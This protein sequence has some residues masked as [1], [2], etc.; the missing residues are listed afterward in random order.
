MLK[1]VLF[2]MDGVIIDSEP[3]HAKAAVLALQ[4][5]NIS[6]PLEY[7]NGFVGCTTYSMCQRI[8]ADY[9]LSLP[10]EELLRSINDSKNNLVQTEGYVVI[11]YVI[12]LIKDL[13]SHG[14]KLMIASS[15]YPEAIEEVM[16]T[17]ELTEYFE[18]Y[19]A[20]SMVTHPKPAPDIFLLAADR[21]KVRPDECIII[22]DSHHGVSAAAA[23]GITSIG[24]VN[25]NSGEQDLRKAAILVEGFDE[26]DYSF[27][28]RIYQTAHKE[29]VTV[30]STE[31]FILRELTAEDMD[32]LFE[33]YRQPEIRAYLEDFSDDLSTERKKLQAY[34]DHIYGYY[35]YGL[36]GV[37]LKEANLLIGQCGV[38]Y[39]LFG[40]EKIYEL[41]FMLDARYQGR[42]YAKEFV[43]AVI[44]YAFEQ[45]ALPA[46]SAVIAKE[47]TRSIRLA[48]SLGMRYAGEG[49]RNQHS[50]LRYELINDHL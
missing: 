24:F 13:Y 9:Q 28:N 19:V 44:R 6:I 29:P 7:L 37:F 14:I 38:E 34:I 26:V 1:A 17:L 32:T 45:L 20:G 46:I 43:T 42:G 27:V 40:H 8:V 12:E 48:V 39:K 18:G 50:C 47:N 15:S 21:L 10:P 4:K 2:D 31:H 22:E 35:G 33:I 41:G 11:P 3:L 16:N 49:I 23:A 25:P 36:W 30:T 5:Y